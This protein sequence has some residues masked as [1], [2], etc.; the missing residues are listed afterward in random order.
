MN[1]DVFFLVLLGLLP[2]ERDFAPV[3]GD[4]FEKFQ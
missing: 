1:T 2:A 4:I 3:A